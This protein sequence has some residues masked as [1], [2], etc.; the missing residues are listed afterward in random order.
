LPTR[1]TTASVAKP[2]TSVGSIWNYDVSGNVTS[3]IEG[4]WL[5]SVDSVTYTT[6]FTNNVKGQPINID[7]PRTDVADTVGFYYDPL[8]FDLDS[9][10]LANG[11]RYIYGDRTSLGRPTTVT[12]PNG[13]VT[14]FGFDVRG[15]L[16]LI[17]RLFGT[18]DS[19]STK[20]TYN[21][22]G[23]LTSITDPLG[24]VTAIHRDAAGNVDK[25]TDPLNNY[26]QNSFDL[27]GNR[28]STGIYAANNVLRA[29]TNYGYD[30]KY[31]VIADTN[32]YGAHG[33]YGYSTAGLLT[34][35]INERSFETKYRYDTLHRL[36]ATVQMYPPDSA[37]ARY[38]Y[39]SHNNVKKVIDPDGW[40]NVS[41]YDDFDRAVRDSSGATTINTF[42][43]DPAGNLTNWKNQTDGITYTYD[44]L[45]RLT[46]KRANT[47]DSVTYQ[48]DGT[49]YPYGKGLLYKVVNRTSTTKYRYD[50]SGRLFKEYRQFSGTATWD[51]TAYTYDKNDNISV[52]SYPTG[53]QVKYTRNAASQVTKVEVDVGSG[54]MTV[55]NNISYAPFGQASSWTFANGVN[56]AIGVD[57]AYRT[58]SISTYPDTLARFAYVFDA[59]GN[60]TLSL[61]SVGGFDTLR[62]TYDGLDRVKSSSSK[63]FGDTLQ[64]YT[65]TPNGNITKMKRYHPAIDSIMLSYSANRLGGTSGAD[66]NNYLSDRFGNISRQVHG[67]QSG[68]PPGGARILG[69]SGP[70]TTYYYHSLW[71]TFDSIRYR[72]TV[73]SRYYYTT[74]MAQVSG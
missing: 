35:Y 2:G 3:V 30:T 58:R 45:N 52:I 73:S 25:I 11:D 34:S 24:H 44:A 51:S 64:Q 23:D 12:G 59:A 47:T 56:V 13:D 16:V 9:V 61:D 42:K 10:K 27:A 69:P 41:Y 66:V 49:E 55:A 46:K 22:D 18:A 68:P 15:R 65:Y 37:R 1:A 60:I 21:V 39:D 63:R 5:N 50:L 54:W 32:A 28:R 7:G 36:T 48:Y 26:I 43:Y 53:R 31:R 57:S 4:G 6:S 71:G 38:E 29:W 70:D 74:T 40:V 33:H 17:T 14:K 72:A 62:Y 20:Y 19:A 67:T 8:T